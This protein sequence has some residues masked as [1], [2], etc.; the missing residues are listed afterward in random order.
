M[1]SLTKIKRYLDMDD[2]DNYDD[3]LLMDFKYQVE[4][5]I[6]RIADRKFKRGYHSEVKTSNGIYYVRN[7]PINRVDMVMCDG[8]EITSYSHDAEAIY[9]SRYNS[10]SELTLQ[11]VYEGG[12]DIVPYDIQGVVVKAVARLYRECKDE[13]YNLSALKEGTVSMTYVDKDILTADE[14]D[15][16]ES[17]RFFNIY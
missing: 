17:Y 6:E 4:S 3:E 14:R 9:L 1:V 15:I 2:A 13:T 5:H 11:I 7:A 10:D 8:K 16:V 12:F